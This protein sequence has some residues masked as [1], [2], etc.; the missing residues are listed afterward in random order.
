MRDLE[1]LVFGEETVDDI[2]FSMR[3][4]QFEEANNMIADGQIEHG[5]HLRADATCQQMFDL[6]TDARTNG[7]SIS[8]LEYVNR[9]LEEHA[10]KRRLLRELRDEG[11]ID[12]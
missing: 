7:D 10:K 8:P 5:L 4:V 12:D 6:A 11:I 1:K 2:S 9:G 3:Q